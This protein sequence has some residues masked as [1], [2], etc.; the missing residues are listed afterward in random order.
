[1]D[2]RIRRN[3]TFRNFERLRLPPAE[4]VAKRDWAEF[5]E[6]R[7]RWLAMLPD[8]DTILAQARQGSTATSD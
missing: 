5:A 3:G 1:L 7:D 2:F 6:T 4:P 8:R